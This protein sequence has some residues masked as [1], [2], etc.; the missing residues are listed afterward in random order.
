MDQMYSYKPHALTIAEL[1]ALDIDLTKLSARRRFLI[2][3]GGLLVGAALGS[4]A[5]CGRATQ[6][7]P[8]E[9]L[10]A[11]PQRIIAGNMS[12]LDALLALDAP[13]IGAPTYDD[14]EAI[15]P[16]LAPL[17]QDVQSVGL[18][19]SASIETV[20]TLQPDL[21]IISDF[22]SHIDSVQQLLQIAPVAVVQASVSNDWQAT[23]HSV[24]AI[25]GRE[26][27]ANDMLAAWDARATA[28]RTQLQ[29]TPPG[30]VSVVRY[31][32]TSA[33][34][35]PGGSSFAGQILDTAGV[36]RPPVQADGEGK[37]FVEVSLE[38]ISMLDGDVIF[39][40][41]VDEALQQRFEEQPLWQQLR[42][43]QT[44]RVYA[45]DQHWFSGN[46][47]AAHAILGDLERYLLNG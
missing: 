47:L 11:N 3:A 2:G 17:A 18:A 21:I 39:V 42:A 23:L 13:V 34:Y 43:V 33:R 31:L 36:P 4:T 26:A 9:Q 27:H 40:I 38:Q 37:S 12:I 41:T 45:V 22:Q 14:R 35:L 6:L 8:T 44:G 20:A 10:P 28:L 7:T 16:Y 5:A 15:P 29:Q 30:E 46:V 19:T 25:V 32:N 1:A 24:A